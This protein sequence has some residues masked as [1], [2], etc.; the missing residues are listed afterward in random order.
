MRQQQEAQRQQQQRQQAERQQQAFRQQVERANQ[1]QRDQNQRQARALEERGRE[2]AA[3]RAATPAAP[4][5]WRAPDDTEVHP[6]GGTVPRG[7]ERRWRR[8]A[9][10]QARGI[11]QHSPRWNTSLITA[12]RLE[13]FAPDRGRLPAGAVRLRGQAAVGFANDGDWVEALGWQRGGIVRARRAFNHSTGAVYRRP[14]TALLLPAAAIAV[15]AGLVS[16]VVFGAGLFERPDRTVT[17]GATGEESA[18]ENTEDTSLAGN[19]ETTETTEADRSSTSVA[20]RSI[21]DP[22]DPA[23]PPEHRASV[24]GPDR[25]EL[26]AQMAEDEGTTWARAAAASIGEVDSLEPEFR[27]EFIGQNEVLAGRMQDCLGEEEGARWFDCA[28]K[29]VSTKR[30]VVSV[31]TAF[32]L[33]AWPDDAEFVAADTL[34]CLA[35]AGESAIRW[36]GCSAKAL[37]GY[38]RVELSE[39]ERARC[40]EQS[41]GDDVEFVRCAVKSP[42]A[43]TD[44]EGLGE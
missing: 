4:A 14:M 10:G 11:Q 28:E 44:E 29:A 39:S 16:L 41:N 5:G 7:L 3:A 1:A 42:E 43:N 13:R 35:E 40:E 38:W 36:L 22:D 37:A 30:H 34:E 9:L 23:L 6:S 15:I 31:E 12:F 25:A 32:R 19:G 2:L 24:I 20:T 17:I 33:D 18:S 21:G 8:S 27:H 26:I